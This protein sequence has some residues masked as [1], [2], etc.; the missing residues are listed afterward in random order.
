MPDG[1]AVEN[2]VV[3]SASELHARGHFVHSPSDTAPIL[4]TKT[5]D[6]DNDPKDKIYRARNIATPW[7]TT[8]R[9]Q[10]AY[11]LVMGKRLLLTP[12]KM[13]DPF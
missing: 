3:L 10:Y 2:G 7:M 12:E 9:H 4:S 8:R 6:I 13:S 1:D 5:K 11:T